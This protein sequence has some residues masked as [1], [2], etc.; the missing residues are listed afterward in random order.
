MSLDIPGAM[1]LPKTRLRAARTDDAET[2]TDLALAAK[3]SWGYDAAFM[4][5]CRDIM[6]ISPDSLRRHPYYVIDNGAGDLLGFYGFDLAD[7]LLTLDWLFV[8]PEAQGR[9]LGRQLFDHAVTVA[10]T[11]QFSYF[12][13]ISDPHAEAFYLKLG[14]VRCG[15]TASDLSPD[16]LLPVLRLDLFQSTIMAR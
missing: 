11:R 10:R 7:G 13:I 2:L 15:S 6:V 8:A 12:Q 3:A 4:A 9:G 16:R 1:S 14:A 5:R